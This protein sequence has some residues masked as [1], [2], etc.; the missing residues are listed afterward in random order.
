MNGKM[1][2]NDFFELLG[3]LD[4][5]IV[6]DAW[7]EESGVITIIEERSLL[8][9]WKIASAAV[10]CIALMIVGVYGLIK[11]KSVNIAPPNDSDLS[12]A[13]S[14]VQ[15]SESNESSEDSC[16][17]E[18]N[19]KF[20]ALDKLEG[21]APLLI[22]I[23]V[24]RN[25]FVQKYDDINLA[26]LYIE[27]TNASEDKPIYITVCCADYS[28]LDFLDPVSE[29]IKITGSGKYAARYTKQYPVG[30]MSYLHFETCGVKY[31]DGGY[32][33]LDGLILNGTWLP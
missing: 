1:N 32:N 23:E 5:D 15:E 20:D 24:D 9:F 13:E 16:I 33:Q 10:A 2:G 14:S 6:E 11:M 28:G 19:A 26:V 3:D 22:P 30:S 12:Y 21:N 29:T 25:A 4:E 17:S 7:T 18:K 31:G 8:S 27:K